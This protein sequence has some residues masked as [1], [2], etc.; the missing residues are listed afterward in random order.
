MFT[1]DNKTKNVDHN[2]V[3]DPIVV[4]SAV[5]EIPQNVLFRNNWVTGYVAIAASGKTYR[6]ASQEVFEVPP[7]DVDFFDKYT[8]PIG[9]CCGTPLTNFKVFVRV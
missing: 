5:V 9:G 8:R 2:A 7:E 6:V 3:V 4:N 1:Q